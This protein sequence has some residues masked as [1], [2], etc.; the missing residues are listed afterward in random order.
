ME[1]INSPSLRL[2]VL[3]AYECAAVEPIGDETIAY[4]SGGGA[5]LVARIPPRPV[6]TPRPDRRCRL[7]PRP[8]PLSSTRRA[9]SP[10][11]GMMLAISY[12][13]WIRGSVISHS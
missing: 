12:T 7:L 10:L 3:Y 2:A 1:Q 8:P 4:L 13:L 5:E 11:G 6:P 9:A